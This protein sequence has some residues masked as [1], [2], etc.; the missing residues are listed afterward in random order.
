MKK[1]LSALICVICLAVFNFCLANRYDDNP[2][3]IRVRYAPN[4][5]A[6]IDL[7]SVDVQEYNPPYYQIAVNYIVVVE[8]DNSSSRYDIVKRYNWDTKETFHRDEYGNWKKDEIKDNSAR[9]ARSRSF[10][11]ALFRAA[12]GMDFYGY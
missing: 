10:C 5:F 7:K 8:R 2:D 1:I 12:Y 4:S 6:Y 11:D 3:Y 9:S